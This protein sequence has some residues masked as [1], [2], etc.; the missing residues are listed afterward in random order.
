MGSWAELEESVAA[1][2]C[3]VFLREQGIPVEEVFDGRDSSAL[4][5]AVLKNGQAL[6]AARLLKSENPDCDW[7]IS[8]VATLRPLRGRGLATQVL[9]AALGHVKKLGFSRSGEEIRLPS[10]FVLI[11]MGIRL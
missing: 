6:S 2:R 1:L 4:P 9:E 10:G 3:A 5:F 8:W 7:R 11:P